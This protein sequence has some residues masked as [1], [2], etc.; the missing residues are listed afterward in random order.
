M[1]SLPV[2]FTQHAIDELHRL[3]NNL[4]LKDDSVLRIGVKG[5]GCSGMSY[6]LAFD[7]GHSAF[8]LNPMERLA[9][10]VIVPV[11]Q[12]AFNIVT[13]FSETDRGAGGFGSTGTR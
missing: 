2:K 9:Q 10:L 6:L 13:E 7:R 11:Q 8:V 12:V 5:G 4:E 3:Q 1:E